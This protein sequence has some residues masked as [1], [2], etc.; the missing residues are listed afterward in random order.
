L[1]ASCTRMRILKPGACTPTPLGS[2]TSA[3]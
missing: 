1:P 3:S 2:L